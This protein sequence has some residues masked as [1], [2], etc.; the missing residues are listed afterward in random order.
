MQFCQATGT[1]SIAPA[2]Y[3]ANLA[4]AP[5]VYLVHYRWVSCAVRGWLA[6]KT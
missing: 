6:R 4:G 2:A 1:L 3:V 5:F